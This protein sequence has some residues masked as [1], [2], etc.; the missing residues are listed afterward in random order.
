MLKN[1]INVIQEKNIKVKEED[2]ECP[3]QLYQDEQTKGVRRDVYNTLKINLMQHLTLQY[4]FP[5]SFKESINNKRRRK[6]ADTAKYKSLSVSI[7]DWKDLGLIAEKTSRTR[8]KMI[9]K[10]IKFYKEN[11]GERTNGHGKQNT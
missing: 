9:N 8:S 6:M 4:I 2:N 7:T 1:L 10:L 5:Y 11:R 3:P